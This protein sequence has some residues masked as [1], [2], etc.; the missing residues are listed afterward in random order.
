M[1]S[2]FDLR[3]LAPHNLAA[4]I[5]IPSLPIAATLISVSLGRTGP[6]R[7]ARRAMLRAANLTWF[8]LALMAAAMFSLHREAGIMRLPIGWPNRFLIVAYCTWVIVVAW[9]AIRLRG[10]DRDRDGRACPDD[11]PAGVTAGHRSG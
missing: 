2:V 11:L 3:Q 8:S 7:P 4:A 1:A 10:R 9:H 6:W 5:A